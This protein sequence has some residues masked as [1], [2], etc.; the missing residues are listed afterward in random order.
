MK[1]SKLLPIL[2]C[3]PLLLTGC[4][5][6]SRQYE[7]AAK[8]AKKKTN[9]TF[10][11]KAVYQLPPGGAWLEDLIDIETKKRQGPVFVAGWNNRLL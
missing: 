4:A 8:V 2:I 9:T 6:V 7:K 5:T 11:P 3:I 1:K 10:N